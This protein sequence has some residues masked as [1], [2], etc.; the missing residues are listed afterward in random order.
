[1]RVEAA[2]AGLMAVFL[3]S[4]LFAAAVWVY[5]DAKTHAG[6]GRSIAVSVGTLRLDTPAAWFLACLLLGEFFIPM[7]VD[8]RGMA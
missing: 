6:R 3:A 4:A 5:S 1:M 2:T 8:S 7:Y